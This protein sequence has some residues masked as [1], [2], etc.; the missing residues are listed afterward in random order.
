MLTMSFPRKEVVAALPE[1]F[2]KFGKMYTSSYFTLIFNISYI[3]DVSAYPFVDL[4]MAFSS[5]IF[6]AS[7]L[8]RLCVK[9][10]SNL[11]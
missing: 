2:W 9:C 7:F 10:H 6:D 8:I 11:D 4:L 1:M 3:F 5:L